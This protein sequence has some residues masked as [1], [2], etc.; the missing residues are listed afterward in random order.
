MNQQGVSCF[1]RNSSAEVRKLEIEDNGKTFV[2]CY[3]LTNVWPLFFSAPT[4]QKGSIREDNITLL[5]SS[6]SCHV[7]CVFQAFG[8]QKCCFSN[9]SEKSNQIPECADLFHSTSVGV[10]ANMK[11]IYLSGRAK[12]PPTATG[13]EVKDKCVSMLTRISLHHLKMLTPDSVG[14]LFDQQQFHWNDLCWVNKMSHL[15]SP[16]ASND[17]RHLPSSTGIY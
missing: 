5:F 9:L 8:F 17:F 11:N 16:Q 2:Y 13:S 1:I 12:C 3:V 6:Q 15:I 7:S 14:L 10:C 4:K